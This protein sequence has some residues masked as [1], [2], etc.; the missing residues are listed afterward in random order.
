MPEII[1]PSAHSQKFKDD[2]WQLFGLGWQ[3]E[4]ARRL[5]IN[6]RTVRRYAN[7]ATPIPEIIL[8]FVA[9]WKGNP[10]G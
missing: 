9:F 8:E 7:G 4:V 3:H 5:G 10:N 1:N 2:C 6:E